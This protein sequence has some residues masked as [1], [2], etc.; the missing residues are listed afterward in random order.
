DS[1]YIVEYDYLVLATGSTCA[2]PVSPVLGSKELAAKVNGEFSDDIKAAE[3]V[4][5]I[6]GG[7]LG[8][9]MAGE[10]KHAD[11]SKR[12]TIVHRGQ[13][14]LSSPLPL[15]F[16]RRVTQ[17]LRSMGV[18]VVLGDSIDLE[19]EMNAV[20][21]E[22]G[23][24][25]PSAPCPARIP[26]SPTSS[27]SD[28][29]SSNLDALYGTHNRMR[30]RP[31]V[32]SMSRKASTINTEVTATMNSHQHHHHRTGSYATSTHTAPGHDTSSN[33]VDPHGGAPV[34]TSPAAHVITTRK[35]IRIET[36][37]ILNA[38]GN[39]V[40]TEYLHSLP[41]DTRMGIVGPDDRIRVYPT[42]QVKDDKYP[43]IFAVGDAND[44]KC[45]KAGC[46]ATH[47]VRILVKNL[48]LCITT[49]LRNLDSVK[50]PELPRLH[51]FEDSEGYLVLALGPAKGI[52]LF[53]HGLVFGN[54]AARAFKGR[55]LQLAKKWRQMG[56]P[57]PPRLTA[58]TG[59]ASTGVIPMSL[60]AGRDTTAAA[61]TVNVDV[62]SDQE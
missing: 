42:L 7:P 20:A 36:D 37:K 18:D 2:Q 60:F 1:P 31:T 23:P 51:N 3:R 59:G 26:A 15:K 24:N 32:P 9:E 53:P 13:Q 49:E 56:L 11:P 17:R 16:R 28:P 30:P 55:D 45:G 12:V 34:P 6:G 44:I 38:V 54:W 8:V 35:G 61:S 25:A 58:K 62:G 19:T 40:H 4:L 29:E 5:I 39:Q 43:Y 50:R 48:R 47:Q 41:T 57:V 10:I 21:A 46:R 22:L 14:L 27:Y 33:S 52:C